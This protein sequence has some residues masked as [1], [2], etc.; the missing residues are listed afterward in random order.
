MLAITPVEILLKEAAALGIVMN[1]GESRLI[2]VVCGLSLLFVT[3]ACRTGTDSTDQ[4]AV[5]EPRMEK[6]AKE[7]TELRERI[8]ALEQE[9]GEVRGKSI[10]AAVDMPETTVDRDVL[11][12]EAGDLP[13]LAAQMR[14]VPYF[15]RGE[16]IGTRAFSI[17]EGSL[18]RK[19]GLENG[20]IVKTVNGKKLPDAAPFYSLFLEAEHLKKIVLVVERGHQN[21]K[22]TTRFVEN[23][24]PG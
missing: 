1:N 11:L 18:F 16:A 3:S 6:L 9:R 15:R 4:S 20:D 21:V 13:A 22:L 12:Q 7:V 14:M 23:R 19:M 8:E 17:K 10:T 2:S 5:S 24:S